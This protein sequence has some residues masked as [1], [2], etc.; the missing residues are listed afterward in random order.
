[1]RLQRHFV[2]LLKAITEDPEQIIHRISMMPEEEKT[3]ILYTFNNIRTDYPRNQTVCDLF[4]KQSAQTPERVALVFEGQQWTYGRLNERANQ[5]ARLLKEYDIGQD[6]PV[7]LM[8]GSGPECI[9]GI[10]GILKAGGAYL[11]MDAEYPEERLRH[12]L[13]DSGARIVLTNVGLAHRHEGLS[14]FIEWIC[15]DDPRIS[16]MGTGNLVKTHGPEDLIY[17]IYTS[18]STGLPKGVMFE[19]RSVVRL[20]K[21]TTFMEFPEK[22]RILQTCSYMFDVSTLEI[23]GAL[24]NGMSLHLTRKETVLDPEKMSELIVREGINTMWLTSPL[25]NHLA[26]HQPE[27]FKPLNC[28]LVGGEAL[29]KKHIEA[30]RRCC[31]GL[32]VINGYGPTENTTFSACLIIEKEY[33]KSIPIG[34]PISNSTA[35]VLNRFGGLQPIGVVGE[36]CVGGEGVARGYMNRPELT[37]ER[38]ISHPWIPEERLYKTGDL[39]RWLP[40]GVLE[41]IGR[42]DG[43]VKIRGFRIEVGEIEQQLLLYEDVQETAIVARETESGSCLYAYFVSKRSI[44]KAELREHLSIRMPDYMLPSYF[45]QV[46]HIPLTPNGKVDKRILLELEAFIPVDDGYEAPRSD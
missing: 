40:D 15:M 31:P 1:M 23:W 19:H 33:E 20:V 46:S 2:C 39:V 21:N 27:M 44:K 25:F 6:T 11:S 8:M 45:V 5:L 13:L 36:L 10:L 24:L 30:V 41:F 38:F 29:S 37:A 32:R 16:D 3:Q 14:A 22:G 18:G 17:I 12:M 26:E 9:V 35:Y 43:Q 34:Q 42:S 4:E 28:L 7:G